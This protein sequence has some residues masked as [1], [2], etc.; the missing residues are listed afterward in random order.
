MGW[1]ELTKPP[2]GFAR[3]PEANADRGFF[4]VQRLLLGP[5]DYHADL[6]IE[7]PPGPARLTL[8][9]VGLTRPSPEYLAQTLVDVPAADGK[10]SAHRLTVRPGREMIV[11]FR[12]H[13]SSLPATTLRAAAMRWE[14]TAPAIV[15]WPQCYYRWPVTRLRGVILGTTA[16]CNASCIHC[17]TNKTMRPHPA[18]GP[19]QWSLYQRLID[20]L[21]DS[22]LPIDGDISFG[23]FAEP[24]ID[25]LIVDR[26]RYAK[27]RL[28]DVP[29]V[30]YSN[31]GAATPA[32]AERIAPYVSHV[33]FHVEGLTEAVYNDLMRPLKAAKVFRRIEAFIKACDRPVYLS[34]PISRRNV[35]EFSALREY[36]LARGAK[37][38]NPQPL[39][40]RSSE[41]LAFAELAFD[42]KPVACGE[43]VVS[44]LL[45]D[46]DGAV[47]VCCSDFEKR[48]IIGDLRR[49]TV[50]EILSNPARRE[51]FENFRSR[52]HDEYAPCR[53]CRA[54]YGGLKVLKNAPRG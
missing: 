47:V 24:L 1:N 44:H 52:R 5:G 10:A 29:L 51:L 27:E 39:L 8:E 6:D 23:L 42:P 18:R 34:C 50:S 43:D 13:S 15:S 30:V 16:T 19:M 54:D 22:G 36:W 21:H 26:L 38:V 12:G 4:F 48:N 41:R 2:G 28:P 33:A 25:P 3:F 7:L 20:G 32:L 46:A 37:D 17:P 31:G 14:D 9:A 49:E 53:E 11:E 40:N 35:N 45:V